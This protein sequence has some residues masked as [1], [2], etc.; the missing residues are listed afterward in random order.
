M[1]DCDF[2]VVSWQ[3][4]QARAVIPAEDFIAHCRA[5]AAWVQTEASGVA[6]P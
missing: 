4:A 6:D 1:Q 5:V 3:T 2:E